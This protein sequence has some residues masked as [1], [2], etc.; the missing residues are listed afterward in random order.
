MT[1]AA[2]LLALA[3]AIALNLPSD[4]FSK[5]IEDFNLST[6]R[7]IHYPPSKY[8]PGETTGEMTSTAL[9]VSEHTDFGLFT[10]LFTDGPG[11]QVKAVEGGKI[12]NAS[13]IDMNDWLDVPVQSGSIAIVNTGALLARWTNDVWCATAHRVVIKNQQ[14]AAMHRYSIAWFVDPDKHAI[15]QVHPKFVEDG[16][17]PKYPPISGLDYLLSRLKEIR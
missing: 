6:M 13:E 5:T 10:F 16:M 8:T 2:K 15:V 4:F 9:R 7:V 14:Q 12:G 11:L 1:N 3:C 17:E